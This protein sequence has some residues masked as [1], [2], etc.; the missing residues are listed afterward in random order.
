L[1]FIEQSALGS[2][3]TDNIRTGLAT[4]SGGTPT[5]QS[6]WTA[7]VVLNGTANTLLFGTT[8]DTILCP[9]DGN[10]NKVPP[11]VTWPATGTVDGNY[12]Q[13]TSYRGCVG[14]NQITIGGG[15]SQILRLYHK[16]FVGFL[17]NKKL[18]LLILRALPMEPVT[19]S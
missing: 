16:Y 3:V 8:V 17:L 4:S 9:S 15:S 18:A 10:R 6:P 11:I 19:L 13:P 7:G 14:D 12:C 1:P 5:V 2:L